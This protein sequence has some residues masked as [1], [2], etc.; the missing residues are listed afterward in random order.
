MFCEKCITTWLLKRSNCPMCR[1]EV[2]SND[3]DHVSNSKKQWN[4]VDQSETKDQ[5]AESE[6]LFKTAL[7]ELMR[8]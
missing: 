4:I 7:E 3:Y 6:I 5:L 8:I 2:D 1:Y